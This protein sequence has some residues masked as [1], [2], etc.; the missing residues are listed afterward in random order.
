MGHNDIVSGIN[1][2]DNLPEGEIIS[3]AA[4][5][6]HSLALINGIIYGFGANNEDQLAEIGSVLIP[7]EIK[8]PIESTEKF[9]KIGCGSSF[10]VAL[11]DNGNLYGWGSNEDG[12]LGLSRLSDSISKPEIIASS[13]KSFSCGYHH[14][15]KPE[16]LTESHQ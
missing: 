16:V 8:I 13:I 15:G 9:I 3:V 12:Q 7:T 10:S 1:K 11:T 6:D 14:I 5:R 2:I 4:G